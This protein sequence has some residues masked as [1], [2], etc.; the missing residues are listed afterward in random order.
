MTDDPARLLPIATDLLESIHQHRLLTTRQ[1]QALHAPDAS[2]RWTQ[3]IAAAL[4]RRGL[5]DAVTVADGR[6]LHYATAAGTDAVAMLGTRAETRRTVVRA[7]QAAGPLRHHT[8][9]VND[10]GVCFVQAARD[11]DDQ[12]G[13]WAWRH[14]IAHPIGSPAGQRHTEHVISDALLTY[15]RTSDQQ[16]S[17]HYRLIELDRATMA[18]DDLAAKLTRYA[19]LYHYTL[20]GGDADEA[21]PLW[22]R[23]YPVFPTV[24]VVL[25][26]AERSAL[27][28]RMETVLALCGLDQELQD[29]P[30]VRIDLCL[31]QDLKDAGPYAPIFHTPG[32]LD[33][34]TDWLGAG[35]ER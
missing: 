3:R 11:H 9:A 1:L 12:C 31:L 26:G 7:E 34:P 20:P 4:A 19:R 22:T 16:T 2:L 10:V 6:R 30:E 5:I 29:A 8:L 17:F 18:A 35:D 13:P 15:Q 21:Q 23:R 24:L 33:R 14:E 27:R 32:A 28:R 25:T